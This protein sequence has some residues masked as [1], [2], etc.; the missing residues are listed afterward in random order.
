MIPQRRPFTVEN[1]IPMATPEELYREAEQL[2]EQGNLEGANAKLAE[3]LEQHPDYALAHSALAK[4]LTTLKQH[5]QAIAHAQ[6]VTELEPN[7]FFSFMA[8]SVTYQRAGK[9]PEAE[10]AMA[11]ARTLQMR[12]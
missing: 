7:D 3:I 5:D 10:D 8:L 6:K 12:Q 9:I 4:N 1:P 11:K 2:K